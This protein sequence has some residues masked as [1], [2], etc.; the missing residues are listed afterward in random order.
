M[1]VRE[2]TNI[3]KEVS[4]TQTPIKSVYDGDV[5]EVWDNSEVNFGSL[6]FG[7]QNISYDSNLCTYTFI[8]YY[9]DRLLQDKSNVNE[10]YTDGINAIQSV[11]NIL[12]EQYRVDIPESINYIP[13]Q[14]Q[15]C[16]YLAGVYATVEISTESTIGLCSIDDYV[17]IDDKDK[18]IEELIEQINK[19]KIEDERLS[20]LLQTILHKLVGESDSE[21]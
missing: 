19:Y 2:L 10:I 21:K 3:I 20:I 5:Y 7:L 6:N 1:N 18:L 14:Q 11:L 4:L 13:F 17:Y 12:N 16:D 9:G 8:F 15:F